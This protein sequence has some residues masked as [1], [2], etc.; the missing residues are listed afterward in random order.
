MQPTKKFLFRNADTSTYYY[1]LV[2]ENT[3][4]FDHP[5]L[6]ATESDFDRLRDAY[7]GNGD[8][9]LKEYLENVVYEADI[10]YNNNAV[11]DPT[12][13]NNK[14]LNGENGEVYNPYIDQENAGYIAATGKLDAIVE[15]SNEV[16]LLAF[17]YRVTGEV[18]YARLAYEYALSLTRWEHWGPA[19]IINTA[20]A[21]AAMALAYD[22]LYDVW[23]G[24]DAQNDPWSNKPLTETIAIDVSKISEAIWTVAGIPVSVVDDSSAKGEHEIVLGKSDRAVSVEAYRRLNRIREEGGEDA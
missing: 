5:Y 10:V 21:T 9:T 7:A 3:N 15:Y 24:E 20:D 19:Y 13:N 2:K 18:K 12:V 1:D 23:T 11:E 16:L 14:L 6:V 17:A 22:W 8:A 4:N